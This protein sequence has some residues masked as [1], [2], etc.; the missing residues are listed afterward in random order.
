MTFIIAESDT[1]KYTDRH[2][3]HFS[4]QIYDPPSCWI[5]EHLPYAVITIIIIVL[6]QNGLLCR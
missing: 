4:G 1:P 6:Q 5:H 3:R 2:Y